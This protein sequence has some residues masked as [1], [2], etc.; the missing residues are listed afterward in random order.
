MGQAASAGGFVPGGGN[1]QF[2]DWYQTS[3][4]PGLEAELATAQQGNPQMSMRELVAGRDIVGE[5]RRKY[6]VR[7]STQ[8]QP[9]PIG[10]SGR[11]SWWE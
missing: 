4:I 9:G 1:T 11:Y 5:A 3:Y 7:P 2:Q 6:A 8:R 10:L